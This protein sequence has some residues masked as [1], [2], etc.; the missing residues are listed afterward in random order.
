MVVLTDYTEVLMVDLTDGSTREM[1][2]SD[3]GEDKV[4]EVA[5]SPDGSIAYSGTSWPS[6]DTLVWETATGEVSPIEGLR[7]SEVIGVSADGEHIATTVTEDGYSTVRV[8]D[9][10]DYEVVAE[11][12]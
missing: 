11:F 6:S 3:L 9:T 7:L 5:L 4:Y 12:S 10:T 8:L 2:M 1:D